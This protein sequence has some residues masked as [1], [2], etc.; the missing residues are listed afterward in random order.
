[1]EYLTKLLLMNHEH[2]FDHLNA[3]LN[4]ADL[5]EEACSTKALAA[6]SRT[7][8]GWARRSLSRLHTA[9]PRTTSLSTAIA[10][11][12]N[13]SAHRC[14]LESA[15]VKEIISH[16]PS[17]YKQSAVIPLLDLAQQQHGGWLPVSAMNVVAEVI[18][19]APIHVYEVAT[20]YSMFN[21]S[22]KQQRMACFLLEKWNAWLVFSYSFTGLDLHG[23]MILTLEDATPEQV[24][25]IVEMLRRGEK[26]PRGTQN[27][28]VC[29]VKR[30][31][32]GF[33]KENKKDAK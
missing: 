10:R 21:R 29:L 19:V 30:F 7:G 3:E 33:G 11:T 9:I 14:W 17:N 6:L 5:L 4:Q 16:Y 23:L 25:E 12:V 22:K 18:E 27:L 1:M 32:E 26:P 15:I 2:Y 28:M 31:E 8:Q 24:V 20:F 13:N